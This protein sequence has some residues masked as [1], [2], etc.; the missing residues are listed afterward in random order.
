MALSKE[1]VLESVELNIP[2]NT[3]SVKWS[4]NIVEDGVVLSSVPHRCC[5]AVEQKS[6][7]LAEV[8]GAEAY[9]AILGW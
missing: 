1:K 3:V 2:G 9:V 4:N 7:F 8:E 5:Y 6:Q